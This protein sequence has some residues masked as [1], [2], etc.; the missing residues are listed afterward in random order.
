M[1]K[2]LVLKSSSQLGKALVSWIVFLS[3]ELNEWKAGGVWLSWSGTGSSW[4][5]SSEWRREE[6][7]GTRKLLEIGSKRQMN[8]KNDAETSENQEIY[9]FPCSFLDFWFSV[10]Y[11]TKKKYSRIFMVTTT[12]QNTTTVVAE[13]RMFKK[14]GVSR[15]IY[16]QA[17]NL[18]THGFRRVGGWRF[19][20]KIDWTFGDESS[21]EK[22]QFFWFFTVENGVENGLIR[23]KK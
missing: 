10:W 14:S 8:L 13:T 1:S 18:K 20:T 2:I 7:H 9:Q 16:T 15:Y 11:V 4:S 21:L 22:P 12:R 3:F 17:C 19:L 5:E 23:L 6:L